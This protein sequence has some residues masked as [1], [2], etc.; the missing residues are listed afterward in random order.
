MLAFLELGCVNVKAQLISSYRDM[1][2][3]SLDFAIGFGS[4]REYNSQQATMHDSPHGYKVFFVGYKFIY[5]QKIAEYL[6]QHMDFGHEVE[7][8]EGENWMGFT[9]TQGICM[10][11]KTS[12]QVKIKAYYDEDLRTKYITITGKA[13]TLIPLFVQYWYQSDIKLDRLKKGGVVYQD[14]AHDRVTFTWTGVNPVIKITA[15]PN[16][17]MV[18]F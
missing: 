10:G 1:N 4:V 12:P 13:E 17:G 5:A 6:V 9:V 11:C 16:V 14:S 8:S 15:N 3:D 2:M 18:S 7:L